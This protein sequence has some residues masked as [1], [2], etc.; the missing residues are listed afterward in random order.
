[1]SDVILSHSQVQLELEISPRS[2]SSPMVRMAALMASYIVQI[3]ETSP[4]IARSRC[5]AVSAVVGGTRKHSPHHS[6]T[7]GT[8]GE[9]RHD[10]GT[11]LVFCECRKPRPHHLSW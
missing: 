2:N 6:T 4:K 10:P 1:P 9:S 7:R 5:R 11:L 8:R 3:L